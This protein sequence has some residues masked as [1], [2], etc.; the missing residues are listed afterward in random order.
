MQVPGRDSFLI[1][2]KTRLKKRWDTLEERES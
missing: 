2:E 1:V